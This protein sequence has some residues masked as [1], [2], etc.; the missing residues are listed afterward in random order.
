MQVLTKLQEKYGKKKTDKLK[1]RLGIAP[2]FKELIENYYKE[3]G[4][5]K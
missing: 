5:R 3:Y 1:K 4:K 2:I